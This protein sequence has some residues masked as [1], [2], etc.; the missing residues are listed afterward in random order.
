MMHEQITLAKSNTAMTTGRNAA[1]IA[2]L[3]KHLSPRDQTLFGIG[4]PYASTAVDA[5]PLKLLLRGFAASLATTSL[6][7]TV[8]LWAQ[9]I[10]TL[11]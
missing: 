9:P 11:A 5:S 4:E 7:L 3:R 1:R 10:S 2:D 6:F 8:G